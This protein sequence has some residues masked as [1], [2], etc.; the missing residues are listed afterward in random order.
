MRIFFFDNTDPDGMDRVLYPIRGE[1][2]Q[3][4]CVVISKSGRTLET[5]NG[6]LEAENAYKQAGVNF[7]KCSVAITCETSELDNYAISNGW[8]ARFP[9]WEWVG[10]RTSELSAVGLLPA[11]LQGFDIDAMLAGA[12]ECDN[13]TRIDNV[14]NN[15]SGLLALM[16]YYSGNGKGTKNMVVIPYK[17]RLELFSKYLQQL[18]MES[19]GKEKDLDG[20]VV[21]QGLTVLGN[22]GSTDQHS[23]IQQ[24]VQ[25]QNSHFVTFIE[26]LHDRDSESVFVSNNSTS[27]DYLCFFLQGT[28]WA[29]TENGR[30]SLTLTF[31]K[32]T[33]FTIGVL[34]AL[35]ERAVGLYASLININPYHQ[36]GVES[37]KKAA[38]RLIQLQIRILEIFHQ[39][40]RRYYTVNEISDLTGEFEAKEWIFKILEHLASNPYRR[41]RVRQGKTSFENQY[42]YD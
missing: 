10:G 29:L 30:E 32:I 12:K 38:N 9:M 11:A 35:F 25:G 40:P 13:Q 37:G 4:L 5:K 19:I 34:I 8:L 7:S 22:K 39:N 15:P 41:I 27:G 33:P 14:T 1:L 21:N 24:L 17:D 3:T 6:M 28:R 16:W 36:P 23:I 2:G 18:I 31:E 26:I 42:I 20:N